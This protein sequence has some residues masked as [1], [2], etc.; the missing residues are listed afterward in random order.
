[1]GVPNTG[2]NIFM[3]TVGGKWKGLILFHL[4]R[5]SVRTKDFYTLIPGLTQK[6]LTDQL[7]QLEKD[8][9]VVRELFAEVPPRVE[10][11]L[12]ELGGT[13]VP[14]LN[15]MCEWGFVRR[16]PGNRERT[17]A[18]LRGVRVGHG[19]GRGARNR[20]LNRTRAARASTT[21]PAAGE[22]VRSA[23]PPARTTRKDVETRMLESVKRFIRAWRDYPLRP[24]ETIGG[25]Y[26]IAEWLGMGSYG[27]SY[28][29]TDRQT[30]REA[31]LKQAK[32]SRRRTAGAL[33]RRERD[34]LLA[35]DHPFIPRCRDFF[36]DR[37]SEW[38]AADY[39]RGRTLE[40][41]I[42]EE[43]RVFGEDD[44]L[45][46][47]LEL[48]DRVDHVHERGYVHLDIRIPNVM[49]DDDGLHLIDFG[50]ARRIGEH[51]ALAPDG[52]PLPGRM[53][54]EIASDLED[55]GHLLLYMLYSGYAPQGGEAGGSDKAGGAPE[56]QGKSA[57]AAEIGAEGESPVEA[58]AHESELSWEEELTLSGPT[59]ALLR[60]LLRLDKPF[61][62][63]KEAAEAI[64]GSLE[65]L[66]REEREAQQKSR[67]QSL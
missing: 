18:L 46:W 1:M 22:F 62:D 19:T 64:R 3:N 53:P 4:S 16:R 48:L 55:A 33:L 52:A 6:V 63:A 9:L 28:R 65:R 2:I 12:S 45:A 58:A 8:G 38:L 54:A 60:R 59:A 40:D 50:L 44:C 25:R 24:G 26:E 49:M 23:A 7:K 57:E 30:G 42:F 37:R 67:S 51:E 14:V 13:F 34:A 32:P 47:A 5:G 41:L 43:G 29:C 11:S 36:G 35:M 21:G 10:Y 27:L 39:V 56:A 20:S 61:T 66:R 31:A 15:A 17:R